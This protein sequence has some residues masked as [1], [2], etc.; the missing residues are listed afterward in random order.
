MSEK[1][2]LMRI[3]VFDVHEDGSETEHLDKSGSPLLTGDDGLCTG[4]C[5]MTLNELAEETAGLVMVEKLRTV[6]L[7]AAM[8]SNPEMV[9]AA[10]ITVAYTASVQLREELE[11]N[12][13]E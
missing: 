3:R 6:E 13:S 4:F 12:A 1:K 5:L 2:Q 8:S 10:A 9:K 7:C 11:N